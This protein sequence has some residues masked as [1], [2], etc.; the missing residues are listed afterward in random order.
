MQPT[1]LHD[2]LSED[3]W[4]IGSLINMNSHIHLLVCPLEENVS[5][6]MK[7]IR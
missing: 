4:Q 1:I 2:L 5:G 6:Y 3:F 7:R